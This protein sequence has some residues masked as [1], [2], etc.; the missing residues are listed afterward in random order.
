M[1]LT[2]AMI[3]PL[4]LGMEFLGSGGGGSAAYQSL[5][6]DIT[7][8]ETKHPIH[9]TPP[10]D[11]AP[12]AFILPVAYIGAPI[13]TLEQLQDGSAFVTLIE[14][15]KKIYGKRPDYL[16]SAEIGGSNGLTALI[17]SGITGIP[18]IDADLLG[19]AFP[20]LQMAS[21]HLAGIPIAPAIICDAQGNSTSIHSNQATTVENIARH[22]SISFGCSGLMSLYPL[23]GKDVPKG[24]IANSMTHAYKLGSLILSAQKSADP[25]ASLKQRM[26][27][28][29]IIGQ[30]STTDIDVQVVDGFTQGTIE[31][32]TPSKSIYKILYQ[33]EYLQVNSESKAACATTPDII[34]LLDNS[35]AKPILSDEVQFGMRVTIV[36]MPAPDCWYTPQG[37]ELV[38]PQAF[39]KT[40]L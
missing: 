6:L 16:L 27:N 37:L 19:R 4:A 32:T 14:K 2:Q 38:G 35:N 18:V 5:L 31:V 12:D 8:Q 28:M 1:K 17:G 3:R 13:V 34:T 25:I 21:T 15:A 30:G 40:L 20:C 11:I 33:N 22:I 29:T 7:L 39:L 23:F 26:P 10:K 9:I 36:S 24:V